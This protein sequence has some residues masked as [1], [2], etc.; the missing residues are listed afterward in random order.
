MV[1]KRLEGEIVFDGMPD[2]DAWRMTEPFPFVT[3]SPVYGNEPEERTEAR[4]LYDDKYVYIGTWFYTEDPSKILST[5]KLRDELKPDCDWLG[6]VLDSYND[7]ENGMSFWTTPAGLRTDMEVFNDARGSFNAEPINVS[8]NTHW[9]VKT[10]VTDVGWFTE[11]LIPV[12][13][14]RFQ[15]KDGEVVMGLIILRWIP[16]HKSIYIYPG[17]P[18]EY[19]EYSA[20][21]VSLAQD[22]VFPGLESRRPL[23]I[24]PYGLAGVSQLNELNE[25][26]TDYE[27]SRDQKLTAGIDLKYGITSNL[28]LDVTLNTDFAQVEADDEK[29]NLTRFDLFFE[30]KRQFFLERASI[31]D[32]NTGGPNTMFYSRRIGLDDDFNLVPIIGGV[33]LIGRKSGWDVGFMNMQT[34]KSENLPSENFGVLRLKKRAFNQNSYLGGVYTSRLGFD[35]SFNQAFG[36]DALIRVTGD[37]YLKLVWGQSFENGFTNKP[38]SLT[39]ARYVFNWERRR[40]VG[41]HY[42]FYFSGS[43]P[44]YNPGIGFQHRE[45]YYIYGAI[46]NYTWMTPEKSSLIRHGPEIMVFDWFSQSRGIRETTNLAMMYNLEFIS[47]WQTRF[48]LEYNFENLFERFELSDDVFVPLG[49]YQFVQVSAMLMTPMTLPFW[50]L[51]DAD[52]GGFYDGKMLSVDVMPSWSI[53]SSFVMSGGYVFSKVNLPDRDQHFISHIG[54]LK[55]M[56]M[57]S[58]KLSLSAFIQYNSENHLVGSNIRFRYNPREGND[59]WVVY[60]EGTYTNLKRELPRPPR[61]AGRTVMLKYTYT[62]RL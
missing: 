18:N 17:I 26:E 52:W 47:L 43:G 58:T 45:D 53:S 22:V 23:Y 9:D 50:M 42:D 24:T 39:N 20:W 15:E 55:A 56:L 12:S 36:L 14:L 6:V 25:A 62:F 57:F 37:E 61:M 40:N 44:E 5:S 21:K 2:E 60:N 31:F 51:I 11:M 3:H 32:F 7:N 48:G 29:V 30:E 38:F 33:R 19:G 27:F 28:T 10:R 59:L 8:W 34:A 13:S 49:E 41:F 46:L 54:R 16:Q 4:I 1:I 35:G